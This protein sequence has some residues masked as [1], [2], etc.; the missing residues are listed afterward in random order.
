MS[1]PT[2]FKKL[3][4]AAAS[5]TLISISAGGVVN[6]SPY[7]VSIDFDTD[8]IGVSGNPLNA[9]SLFSQTTA[10]KDL[11]APYG[12][13]TFG[14]PGTLSGGAILG[15]T[16]QDQLDNFGISALSGS[17]FLAFNREANLLDGGV[18]TDPL[19]INFTGLISGFYISASGGFESTTFQLQAFDAKNILIGNKTMTTLAGEWGY[20]SF[21]SSARRD[22]ISQ[23]VL[24][25]I[26]NKN[27]FVY[28]DLGFLAGVVV[29]PEPTSVLGLLGFGVMGIGSWL[30]G[31]QQGSAQE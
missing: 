4:I 10:L 25:E 17:N 22:N 9:P 7:I 15:G 27:S 29:I 3:S 14:E 19:I 5:V 12:G 1:N 6:A 26:G 28:D 16:I 21:N 23:I 8:S 18:P 20:L 13:V 24:T 31:K 2:I 30:K 11:Y